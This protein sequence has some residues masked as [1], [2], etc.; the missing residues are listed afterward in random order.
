[1]ASEIVRI[2]QAL[3]EEHGDMQVFFD[4]DDMCEIYSINKIE[5]GNTPGINSE[6]EK[7]IMLS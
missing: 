4:C 2:F 1:M 7:V 3:I 6:P 5:I